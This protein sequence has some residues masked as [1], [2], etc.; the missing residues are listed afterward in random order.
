MKINEKLSILVMLEKS[1]LTSDG[2]APVFIRLT[3]EGKRAEMSLGQKVLLNN[4]N[5]EAGQVKGN[6]QEARL[7]NN[8]IDMAKIKLRQHY[9]H[10]SL[11]NDFVSAAMVKQA[12]QGKQE[13]VKGLL[14]VIDFTVDKMDKKVQ[15]G[16]RAKSSL[17]KWKTTKDKAIAFIKYAYKTEDLPL[18]KLTV[19]FAEDFIDYLMLEQHIESNTANKYL[20]TIRGVVTNAV[21]RGWITHNPLCAYQCTYIEPERDILDDG[22]IL[23]LYHKKMPVERLEDVKN[24]YLFMCFTGFAYKDASLLTPENIVN[25]FDGQDWIV[26]NRE[27]VTKAICRENV[28]LLPIAKEI[29]A[30]YADNPYCRKHN[31][32]LPVNSNQKYNAY[33][34]EIA[35]I[36]GIKK[37]LTTHTARHTFATTVTLA[38]GVPLETVSALLGHRSIKT[39]QIYAKIV[40]QKISVDMND[41]KERLIVKMP[42]IMLK[43]HAA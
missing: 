32:L 11:S 1:K 41:L 21:S 28:P 7:V 22:E 26:K 24:A 27:K 39:T 31:V 34:K 37:N 9:D 38:N 13:K 19:S 30:K 5:I 6:S 17:T 4:W 35:D 10:L 23:T 8:A 40:A 18:N 3:V 12:Y 43:T 25:H 20:K 33:L 29:I 42:S 15:N 16:K 36:C 2:K 14:E